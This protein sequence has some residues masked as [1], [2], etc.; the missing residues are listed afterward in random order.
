MQVPLV[1]CPHAA[2]RVAGGRRVVPRIEAQRGRPFRHALGATDR[3]SNGR[4]GSCPGEEVCYP[5]PRDRRRHHVVALGGPLLLCTGQAVARTSFGA[6]D[7]RGSCCA[8]GP[9][10]TSKPEYLRD[11]PQGGD[12]TTITPQSS[13]QDGARR[14]HLFVEA[15][16][17]PKLAGGCIAGAAEVGAVS[18][19]GRWKRMF[20]RPLFEFDPV[21]IQI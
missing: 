17:L 4:R 1:A 3:V 9:R 6:G 13:E 8:A 10:C 15:V 21:A 19:M 12:C 2:H 14:A 11:Q 18:A 20:H 5:R 16:W 7:A